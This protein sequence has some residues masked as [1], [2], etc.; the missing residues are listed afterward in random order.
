MFRKILVPVR[1]DGKGDNVFG[2]A[3]AIAKRFKA[4]IEVTHCR[5]RPDDML[6]FGV[7]VPAFLKEMLVKQ[8][9]QLDDNEEN[10][11]HTEFSDLVVEYGL[12]E[13]DGPNG[14]GP[15][16]SWVEELGK[17]IDV[18]KHHG[19]LSDLICVAKPDRDRNLGANTLKT[20]LFNTGT[21]VMM[22]PPSITPPKVLGEHVSI[23]WNGSTEASR[24]VALTMDMITKAK[25]VTVLSAGDEIH[26]ATVDDLIDYLGVRGVKVQVDRFKA[27]KKIGLEL[28]ERSQAAGADLMI[29]GAYGDS[30]ES[31]A[32]FGGNTQVIVDNAQIPV[33]FVH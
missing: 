9:G 18:I 25:K 12:K 29:M 31:E 16:A 21:P 7:P 10:R 6:P 27:K 30:H 17:Q 3:V 28:I 22:C 26:G 4:H 8:A 33:V 5:P 13:A 23:A 14:D 20:A 24:A 2:H 1:G 15:T 19:R 32:V 11:L